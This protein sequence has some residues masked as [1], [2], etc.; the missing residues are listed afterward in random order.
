MQIKIG[1][2]APSC[3]HDVGPTVIE[4]FYMNTPNEQM[5]LIQSL[6]QALAA[7]GAHGTVGNPNVRCFE[8]HLS[9]VLV[10][11]DFAYKLKKAVRLPLRIFLTLP[12]PC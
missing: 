10:A 3:V 1:K 8:T 4:C 12:R 7:F 2:P 11:G 5:I 6:M 9:W